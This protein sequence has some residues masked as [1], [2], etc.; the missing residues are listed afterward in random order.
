MK[1]KMIFLAWIDHNRRSQLIAQKLNMPLY[2]VQSLKRHYYSAP[3]RY[4]LQTVKTLGILRQEKP[5]VVFIQNPPIFAVLIVY[6]YA[7]FAG[8]QYIID[9]HT[10]ALIAPWWKWSLPIHGFLSRRALTTMVTNNY[11]AT[12]VKNWDA[13]TFILADIPTTFPEGSAYPVNGKFSIAV[14]NTFSPDEPIEEILEAATDLSDVNFY[15]TGN[16]LRA[17]KNYLE[18]HPDNV[19]F[20][21]FIPDDKYFG[22][23]RAVQAIMVLTKDNHTMQRGACEAVS[24]GK[25]IITSKWPVL[26]H[27]FNKGTL[28]VENT[29]HEI[30]NAVLHMQHEKDRLEVEILTLQRERWLEWQQ[31]QAELL[32]LIENGQAQR[33]MKITMWEKVAL[34]ATLITALTFAIRWLID[35]RKG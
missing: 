7:R 18:N 16:L 21:G 6:L 5:D 22:L 29:R 20:T 30:K 32:D 19:K 35:C 24:L 33:D 25:P 13:N 10:G 31:K 14:I 27:Y 1:K 8:A 11:L 3:L 34:A 23:L 28:H 9:S 12:M 4:I 15:I 26:E 17:K 2:L